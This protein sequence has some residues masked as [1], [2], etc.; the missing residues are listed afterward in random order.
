VVD[1]FTVANNIHEECRSSENWDEPCF[2][3]P[4]T[5]DVPDADAGNNTEDRDPVNFDPEAM[6]DAVHELYTGAKSSKLA[7]TILLLNLCMVH[8]VSN[9]F[10]DELFSI[11]HAHLLPDGNSLPKN[12]YATW[13][14]T[15]KLGLAY[16]SIHACENGYILFRGEY[17]NE[18]T[19]PK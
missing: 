5:E 7:T 17:A 6:E 19:C 16:T 15:K 2:P 9:C 11:L 1:A 12:H 10:V 3:D 18:T 13:T 14:L 4:N 8:G